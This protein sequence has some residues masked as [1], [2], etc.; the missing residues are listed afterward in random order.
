MGGDKGR[1]I[2]K[3]TLQIH[4][5]LI[6]QIQIDRYGK[7]VPILHGASQK[8][9]KDTRRRRQRYKGSNAD[10]SKEKCRQSEKAGV[11][12]EG[13][14][15]IFYKGSGYASMAAIAKDF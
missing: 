2:W 1:Q 15:S 7:G 12:Q 8:C 14:K 4:F 11:R 3:G 5:L 13:C 9:T 10:R 6:T